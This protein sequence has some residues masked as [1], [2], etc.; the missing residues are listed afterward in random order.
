MDKKEEIRLDPLTDYQ[1][2]I[3]LALW[4]QIVL[5]FVGWVGFQILGAIIQL[6]VF[7]VA[8][9]NGFNGTMA[10]ALSTPDNGMLVNALA[11]LILVG[12]LFGICNIDTVKL[13]K[14]FAG[15]KPY[16][17]AI[18]CVLSIYTFN[19]IWSSIIS[20]VNMPVSDNVNQASIESIEDVYPLTSLIIFGLIGPVCEELTYRV[21][22][23]SLCKRWT[24]AF[25][26]VITIVVFAFIHFHFSREP[27]PLLNEILNLPFYAFAAAAFSFVYDKFGFASSVSAHITNNLISL[28]ISMIH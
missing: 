27:L 25:A 24:R 23:F 22:L 20:L 10:E 28:I 18:I 26:Y 17:A 16:V 6:I 15:W 3:K 14:S 4:K 12:A 7:R 2:S 5:F 1:K 21:G 13:A 11:Y 8:V 19:L 9:N